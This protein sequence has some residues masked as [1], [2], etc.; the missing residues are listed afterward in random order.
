M[1]DVLA[2]CSDLPE[3]RLAKGDTLIEEAVR[4]N[5]LYVLKSGAFEIVRNGVRVVRIGEPGAFLGEISAVLGSAPTANVVAA[6][7][8]TVHVV[9]NASDCVRR[10]PD[11]T[12]AI[13]QLLAR[14]L[15]AVT[16]YLV[17]IKRQ[18]ADSDTHLALM[19]QVLGNLIAMHPSVSAP[20]S[21][22]NDVPDY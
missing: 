17:D 3:M 4:T 21:E 5:R 19:D 7:D 2:I 14:R 6:E 1:N 18:Y 12:Y 8:S 15:S 10:Q 13:A 16:A 9:E 20:G 11:L 22:R